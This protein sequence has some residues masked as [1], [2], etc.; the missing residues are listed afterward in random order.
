MGARW[1]TARRAAVECGLAVVVTLSAAILVTK[2]LPASEASVLVTVLLGSPSLYLAWR[3]LRRDEHEMAFTGDPAQVADALASRVLSEWQKQLL[4]RRLDFHQSMAVPWRPAPEDLVPEHSEITRIARTS[5]LAQ[6]AAGGAPDPSGPSGGHDRADLLSRVPTRRLVILGEWGSGKSVF[7]VHLV[8]ELLESRRRGDG[9]VP[10]LMSL[11]GWDHAIPL[12]EWLVDQLISDFRLLRQP[13]EAGP[14]TVPFAEVLLDLHLITLVLDGL[15]ELPPEHRRSAVIQINENLSIRDNLV[16]ACRTDYY[17][18]LVHSDPEHP[19]MVEGAAGIALC[20]PDLSDVKRYLGAGATRWQE[21][22]EGPRAETVRQALRRPLLTGLA[23]A[24]YNQP[25]QGA[26]LPNLRDL[27]G[28]TSLAAVEGHLLDHLITALY[29]QSPD[30]I[31]HRCR[32]TRRPD[33]A[34]QVRRWFIFLAA[35]MS[36][37]PGPTPDR[38]WWYLEERV[39]RPLIG[40][41]VG[42]ATA[43]AVGPVAG[44][45]VYAYT[46]PG[47]TAPALWAGGIGGAVCGGLIGALAA[48]G[49]AHSAGLSAPLFAFLG[50]IGRFLADAIGVWAPATAAR[51]WLAAQRE[52]PWRLSSFLRDAYEHHQVLRRVGAGYEFRH[53]HLRD[54]LAETAGG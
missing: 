53:S 33:Q 35:L 5:H 47:A 54:R 6:A 10:V 22:F 24:V 17:R 29:R 49:N 16:V 9:P 8:V 18:D 42:L 2:R 7:L 28:L 34:E 36:T 21:I 48:S 31:V 41:L 46:P 3:A 50:A 27:A 26:P 32:W 12:R 30:G 4:W 15:D 20:E 51:C 40:T 38:A 1:H 37:H 25:V 45:V 19:L 14:K 23:H 13:Y 11:A 52:L 44:I 43:L 39:P